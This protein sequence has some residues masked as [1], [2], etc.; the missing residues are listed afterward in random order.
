MGWSLDY[1]PPADPELL[2]EFFL[3]LGKA[4]YLATAFER[5]CQYILQIEKLVE[6]LKQTNDLEASMALVNVL[7]FRQLGRTIQSLGIISFVSAHDLSMLTRAK[8]ARNYIAH[9]AGLI[10]S[11]HIPSK[12]ILERI[13]ALQR[14]VGALILGDNLVS[15]WIYEIEEK[16]P[17]PSTI[18]QQYASWIE[19]WVFGSFSNA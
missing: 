18:Q 9:E 14:E 3:A 15:V 8:D 16:K 17:A 12:A 4:L 5:K 10:G 2:N 1:I 13:G 6:S 11:L 7:K 19:E